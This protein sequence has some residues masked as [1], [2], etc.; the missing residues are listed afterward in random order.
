MIPTDL[1]PEQLIVFKVFS[2][3][4]SDSAFVHDQHAIPSL[5][6]SFLA[7]GELDNSTSPACTP[8]GLGTETWCSAACPPVF[9]VPLQP[10]KKRREL[11]KKQTKSGNLLAKSGSASVSCLGT[12]GTLA[13]D[14]TEE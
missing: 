9:W 7:A 11:E 8:A 5:P 2:F 1:V 3:T 6:K 13:G 14:R 12:G 4:R 10:E